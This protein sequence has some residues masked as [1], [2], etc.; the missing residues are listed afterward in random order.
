MSGAEGV[1]RNAPFPIP[2]GARDFRAVQA[3]GDT[4][5]H[6]QCAASHGAHD[7]ALHGA[8]E[9]HALFDLLRDAVGDQLRS[10][11][12]FLISAM[13]KRTSVTAIPKSFAVS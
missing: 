9:H 11:S 8:A 2:L 6:A 10:S 3:P 7:G 4:H 1:Q 5:L 12:G 13:F